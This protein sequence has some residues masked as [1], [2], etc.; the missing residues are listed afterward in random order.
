MGRSQ[1]ADLR[2]SEALCVID[3][4]GK[5]LA[6]KSFT[7]PGQQK[8][9]LLAL[10]YAGTSRLFAVGGLIR[11]VAGTERYEGVMMICLDTDLNVNWSKML[12]TN[13]DPKSPGEGWSGWK[14][15]KLQAADAYVWMCSIQFANQGVEWRKGS[16]VLIR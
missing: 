1:I 14:G 6:A 10:T 4:T 11:T 16:F 15:N 7:L 9:G 3:S 2:K 12:H 5:V 13:I 8:F